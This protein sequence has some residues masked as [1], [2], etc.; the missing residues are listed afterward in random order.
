MRGGY[1][2]R[3]L[4]IVDRLEPSHRPLAFQCSYLF[5]RRPE[6]DLKQPTSGKAFASLVE[7][8]IF[9]KAKNRGQFGVGML[10]RGKPDQ[11][12][13]CFDQRAESAIVDDE[14]TA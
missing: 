8:F 10:I 4:M 3:D 9:K 1:C 13:K 7:H 11:F 14:D 2:W 5:C 6:K 12:R